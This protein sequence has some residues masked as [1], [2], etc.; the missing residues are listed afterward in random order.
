MY[1]FVIVQVMIQDVCGGGAVC[2]PLVHVRLEYLLFYYICSKIEAKGGRGLG[3]KI[4]TR[5][6]ENGGLLGRGLKGGLLL[7][8]SCAS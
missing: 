5:R 4:D 6:T 2:E 8:V 3:G 1:G 7:E